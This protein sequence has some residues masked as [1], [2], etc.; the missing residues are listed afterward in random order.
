MDY[1]FAQVVTALAETYAIDHERRGAFV[2]RLQNLQKLGFPEG[3]N[4]GRGKAARY[5][6]GHVFLIGVALELIQLGLTPERAKHV[7]DD[8]MHAVAMAA[9][10]AVYHGVP[11]YEIKFPIFLYL[12]P[13]VLRYLCRTSNDEDFAAATFHYGGMA[14]VLENFKDWFKNGVPRMAFFSVSALV[15]DIASFLP[16]GAD[17]ISPF[18]KALEDWA[19]PYIHN[20]SE[21]DDSHPQT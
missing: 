11:D 4:T 1:S 19:D 16:E 14:Q 17:D 10:M 2:A 9:S 8:D 15:H 5:S 21:P 18:Y 13:A 20:V 6:A 12:D 7:I 3:T